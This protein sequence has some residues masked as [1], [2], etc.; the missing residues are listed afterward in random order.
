MSFQ[1][2]LGNPSIPPS[3]LAARFIQACEVWNDCDIG[4]FAEQS[5]FSK[6]C[7]SPMLD[8]RYVLPVVHVVATH[9]LFAH[10]EIARILLPS[11]HVSFVRNTRPG[12]SYVHQISSESKLHH[13]EYVI[14]IF[15]LNSDHLQKAAWPKDRFC[16]HKNGLFLSHIIP[17]DSGTWLQARNPYNTRATFCG[18]L[19][20][21]SNFCLRA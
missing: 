13:G 12:R 11:A 9:P 19:S 15:P 10:I 16:N 6:Q 17:S 18:W 7:S 5:H 3:S 4:S 21:L 2:F 1:S 14:Y 20:F 8:E